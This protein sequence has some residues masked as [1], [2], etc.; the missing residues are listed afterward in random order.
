VADFFANEVPGGGELNN[1]ELI[2]ILRHRGHEVATRK[3]ILLDAE[4]VDKLSGSRFIVANFV[5]LPEQSKKRLEKEKYIIYEHDHKYLSSRD[6]ALY[7]NYEA[8]KSEIINLD[9]YKNAQATLC[10]S[11]FHKSIVDK[12]LEL[13]N[14]RSLSGNL[15]SEE[16]LDF[17]KEL[18]KK[19]KNQKHAIMFSAIPHKNV[20]DAVT[21][22]SMTKK[23]YDLI[24]QLPYKEFLAKLGEYKKLVF[25]PKTPETLSRILVE[26]RMM[27]MG[28]ITNDKCGAKYEEWFS[29]K[30]EALIGKVREM[31][32]NIPDL[33][34]KV[35]E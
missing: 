22:C 15:W 31:R 5:G 21:Y 23:E 16:I 34:E 14:T 18:S 29:L 12:N 10:Q 9:F 2:K 33:V 4:E 3:S 30:G 20:N 26:A 24:P 32:N 35:F 6:P 13:D 25:F 27:N 1:D 8:P 7:E 28:V 17:L 19:E 11:G